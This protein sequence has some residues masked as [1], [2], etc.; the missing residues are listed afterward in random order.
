[1]SIDPKLKPWVA[2]A[3][4][5]PTVVVN[6]CYI[7]YS[8]VEELAIYHPA[9]VDTRRYLFK[10][11]AAPVAAG[12][13]PYACVDPASLSGNWNAKFAAV[14]LALKLYPRQV[15][16]IDVLLDQDIK[17]VNTPLMHGWKV[18]EWMVVKSLDTN[19]NNVHQDF[20]TWEKAG[21]RVKSM[22]SWLPYKSLE[23]SIARSFV[24]DA[25]PGE[26]SIHL[27]LDRL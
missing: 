16:G 20:I 7:D 10:H 15:G 2:E 27:Y 5:Q 6:P 23:Q 26:R 11:V 3:G 22:F 14:S 4:Q 13:E 17:N 21:A 8:A 12:E 25:R 18:T 19:L 9:F 1:M 24:V